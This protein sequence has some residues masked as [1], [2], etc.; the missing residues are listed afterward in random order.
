MLET[1]IKILI[2]F[3]SSVIHFTLFIQIKN[4]RHSRLLH[5]MCALNVLILFIWTVLRLLNVIIS[6]ATGQIFY[7]IYLAG[8]VCVFFLPATLVALSILLV[9][10][11]IN[12]I[13]IYILIFAPPSISTL[14]L[15]TNSFHHLFIKSYSPNGYSF[16][17]GS[18]YYVHCTWQLIYATFAVVYLLFF[19]LKYTNCLTRQILLVV[20]GIVTPIAVDYL[21]YATYFSR[22]PIA[23]PDSIYTLSYC[24][25]AICLTFAI[26]RYKFL[27]MLPIAI[28]SVVDF[29]SDSFVVIDYKSNV[30]EVS[31]NFRERFG[32]LM[33]IEENNFF[34]ALNDAGL[35]QLAGKLTEYVYLS[36]HSHENAKIEYELTLKNEQRFFEIEIIHIH[37]HKQ[38]MAIL[39]FFRDMTEHRQVL[40]LMEEN[41]KQMMEQARLISLQNLI[42]GISHNIKSPLMS[43]S[44]GV[45]ALKNQTSKMETL[46][47]GLNLGEKHR[48]CADII[49]DMKKW[50]DSIKNY[51]VYISDIISAV[52]EQTTSMNGNLNKSFTVD[53]VLSK[54]TILLDF[55]LKKSNCKLDCS[56]DLERE[57]QIEGDISV[58]TQILGNI[59]INATHSYTNGGIIILKAARKGDAVLFTVRDNGKGMPA[60]VKSKI[61][62]EM[63]T[64]KGKDGSGL[65]LYFAGIAIKSKFMG[66]ITLESEE[67]AGT[68]VYITIPLKE[69]KNK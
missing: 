19:S 57:T 44:G 15:F 6:A 59:I 23:I 66:A 12:S 11:K 17:F 27:D 9:K 25:T 4:I 41:S 61:F 28:R 30:L 32:Q 38:F 47:S 46:L 56:V 24:F 52:K 51:L 37:A 58:L 10:E 48:E 33:D 26:R 63:I 3:F 1:T 60:E 40:R 54:V 43:A 42:G 35:Y 22:L 18:Y 5:R 69:N 34:T 31:K 14:M 20:L 62:N 21:V 67:G 55:E 64:T 45:L 49:K 50:E 68:T 65:G 8:S 53:D 7:P 13:L 29:I 39:I 36:E 2:Y 16:V